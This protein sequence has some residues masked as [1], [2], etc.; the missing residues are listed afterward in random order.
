MPASL[1]APATTLAP[2]P[3]ATGAASEQDLANLQADLR[4][5]EERLRQA[6]ADSKPSGWEK[7]WPAILGLIGVLVGGAINVW[8]QRRQRAASEQAHRAT[9]AFEAQTKIIDYRSRQAHEL[10]HPLWLMLQRSSGVRD[11]LCDHLTKKDPARFRLEREPGDERDHLFVYGPNGETRVRF[12]LIE[13]MHELATQHSEILPLVNEI[14][15]IGEKMSALIH[16]KGG[17]VVSSHTALADVLGRYLAHFSI[18]REVAAKASDPS[19]LQGIT[20]NVLYPV[21]MDRELRNGITFLQD[22]LEK[23]SAFSTELWDQAMPGDPMP[24]VT[25]LESTP[26]P[27]ISAPVGTAR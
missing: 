18:L 1:Q 19:K 24:S 7:L 2:P 26:A 8:V 20:Y 21:G 11:Q 13:A 16:D 17:L 9:T 22:T 10:Y 14:V 27:L 3:A 15:A 23:W 12:R 25:I 5:S 6:I 4:A